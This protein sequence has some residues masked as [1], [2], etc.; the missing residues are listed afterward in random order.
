MGSSPRHLP[1]CCRGYAKNET[2]YNEPDLVAEAIADLAALRA[3]IAQDDPAAAQRVA[4]H[5]ALAR[6]RAWQ[7]SVD[8]APKIPAT[9]THAKNLAGYTAFLYITAMME[10]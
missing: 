10:A 5:I 4:L 7:P 1:G 3:Y 2:L 8:A 6:R 9:T